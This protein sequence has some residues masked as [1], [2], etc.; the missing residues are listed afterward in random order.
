MQKDIKEKR[1]EEHNDVLADIFNNLLFEE[2]MSEMM[3]VA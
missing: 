3:I 1:L 2:K